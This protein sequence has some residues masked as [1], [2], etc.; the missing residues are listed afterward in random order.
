MRRRVLTGALGA[1]ALALS[2]PLAMLGRAVL[3]TPAAV[4]RETGSRP[5]AVRVGQRPRSPADRAAWR[6]LAADQVEPFAE[7]VRTYRSVV[8]L[9]ALSGQPTWSIRIARLIPRLRSPQERAQ[10]FVMAGRLLALA[11]GDGLGVG[12]LGD[13]SGVAALLGQAADDFRA[14]ALEDAAN[15]DAKY[16]LELLLRQQAARSSSA[17][18]TGGQAKK[19]SQP[20]PPAEKRRLG[21]PSAESDLNHAG[22]YAT[23][24]GY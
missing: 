15:E 4:A 22:V 17:D 8:A 10:A 20:Q 11:A 12:R 21:V 9:P 2:I 1:V 19:A 7:I 5:A 18:G 6:L 13:S 24:S 14:A 23:G 16:D 3:A